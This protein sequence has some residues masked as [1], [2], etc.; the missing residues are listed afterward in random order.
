[1]AFYVGYQPYLVQDIG[2]FAFLILSEDKSV[3]V[4]EI[5][6]RW[7][8][9]SSYHWIPIILRQFQEDHARIFSRLAGIKQKD[10]LINLLEAYGIFLKDDNGVLIAAPYVR[11]SLKL[12]EYPNIKS[13]FLRQPRD[14]IRGLPF[15]I[16]S[17]NPPASCQLIPSISQDLNN[18]WFIAHTSQNP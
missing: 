13:T 18:L 6:H 2:Y 3:S 10:F 15:F 5:I 17:H 9:E 12:N 8:I 1:M 16:F 14:C 4:Q 7:R 11:D